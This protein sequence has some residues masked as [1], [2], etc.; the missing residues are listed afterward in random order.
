[1]YNQL[2][3]NSPLRGLIRA[4]RAVSRLRIPSG[5]VIVALAFPLLMAG[6]SSAAEVAEPMEV[7][8]AY[9]DAVTAGDWDRAES[10]WVPHVPAMSRRL[11]IR[12]RSVTAKYDCA[13]PVYRVREAIR[14]GLVRVAVNPPQSR[15]SFLEVPVQLTAAD[16]ETITPYYVVPFGDGWRLASRLDVLTRGWTVW[17]TRFA[18]VHCRDSALVNDHA[19]SEID[20]FVDSVGRRLRVPDERM[21]LLAEKKIDYHLGHPLDVERLTG[22]A[23]PGLTDLPSDAVI[24]S[25][26]PH[27]HELVHLLV[28]FALEEAGLYT[29]PCLQE[30]LAVCWGGRWGK[31]PEVMLQ[32]GAFHGSGLPSDLS[33][34]VSGILV[35]SLVETMG[36]DQFLRLS[37]RFSGS[38]DAVRAVTADSVRMAV[39][40]ITG[41]PWSDVIARCHSI[42]SAHASSGVD[43]GGPAV[44]ETV[45]LASRSESLVGAIGRTDSA[46]IFEIDA[47]GAAPTGAI[48]F[49]C[50]ADAPR[51]AYQSR[52]FAQHVPGETYRGERLGLVFDTVEVGLYDYRTDNLLGKFAAGFSLAPGIWNPDTR[53]VRFSVSR[54]L[55]PDS[56]WQGAVLL[57]P[58]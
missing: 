18:A 43:P 11:G 2:M 20:R 30:G 16:G 5:G 21:T 12:Y 55:L 15:E 56:V 35:R 26:L 36:V 41:T 9:L 53:R 38:N 19:L 32:L 6:H 4:T 23:T 10:L 50:A 28:N 13:S 17:Q 34:A 14:D 29:L 42:A 22:F 7:V 54:F 33:Y 39:R 47:R 40:E 24:S 27:Y 37:E 46:H 57:I 52:L 48:L 49:G 31:S 45:H 3:K 44:P 58:R 51:A 1:M 25:Y 8:T